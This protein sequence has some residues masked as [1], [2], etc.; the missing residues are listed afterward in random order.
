MKR[1]R[2]SKK[3]VCMKE[4][5]TECYQ[6]DQKEE[7]EREF[8]KWITH[9]C[10]D[11]QILLVGDG[12]FSFSLSLAKA[13]GSASNIVASSLDSYA[14]VTKKYKNA[15]SNL[16][17]LQKLGAYLLHGVD[18]TKM[19]HHP[20]LKIRRFDRIIFNFP[21][22][23]FH[24][25][26]DNLMMI[27]MHMDLVFGFFKN[28]SHML[29]INGE[30]HVNHKTTPPFDTWNIEKLAEQSF[31]MMIE[32]ADFKQE[33]YP[34]YNNKRGHRSRCDDP[35]PLGKCSTFKFIYNPRSMKDHFRRNHVEVSRQQ[36]TTNLIHNMDRIP[37]PVDLNHHPQTR[38]PFEVIQNME[39][40]PA[41]VDLNYHPGASLFQ[42]GNQ[43]DY[44]LHTSRFPKTDRLDHYPQTSVFP[45]ANQLNHYPQRVASSADYYHHYARDMTQDSQRLLQPMES[46]YNQS[47]QQWPTPTNCELCLTEHHR[48]MDVTP[49]MPHGARNYDY[50]HYQVYERS[51]TY[52]QEKLYGNGQRTSDCYDI[53]R[54]ELERYNAEVPRREFC[55]EIYVMQ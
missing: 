14:E 6:Q 35:F 20:D 55:S 17:E 9:Y 40:I 12:D 43:L 54:H 42:K 38:L 29:R 4:W 3:R 24:R 13:F 52:S 48:R 31:L 15:K 45:K 32:C 47:S 44:Y 33:A 37:A 2:K 1:P 53:A 28:A 5:V 25:K 26:E 34:G 10:S 36:M 23:G 49:S 7:Y 11:H 19:K 30:V 21:H 22:A 27:K 46:S 39:R 50:H 16:E 18:A 41:P 8:P 51:S